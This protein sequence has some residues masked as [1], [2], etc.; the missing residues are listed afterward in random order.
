MGIAKGKPNYHGL[1]IN[2]IDSLMFGGWSISS[3]TLIQSP[4]NNIANEISSPRGDSMK[5]N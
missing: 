3:S 1:P 4:G 2:T 5:D